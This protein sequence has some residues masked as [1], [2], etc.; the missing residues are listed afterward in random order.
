MFIMGDRQMARHFTV[1][2]C[3]CVCV[4]FLFKGTTP[5][6]NLK[7]FTDLTSPQLKQHMEAS[8]NMVHQHDG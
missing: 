3:V 5:K 6:G 4:L 1:C 2:V 8:I 7:G